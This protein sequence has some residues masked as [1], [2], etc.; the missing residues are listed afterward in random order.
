MKRGLTT[1]WAESPLS[2]YDWELHGQTHRLLKNVPPEEL[3][4]WYRELIGIYLGIPMDQLHT[5]VLKEWVIQ[6]GAGAV[7]S[8][9]PKDMRSF[10]FTG[11]D[12]QAISYWAAEKPEEVWA[13]LK[14]DQPEAFKPQVEGIL[15]GV[16]VKLAAKDF[17][18]VERELAARQKDD[19]L[20][21][22]AML[23]YASGSAD[24]ALRTR[25]LERVPQSTPEESEAMLGSLM[26]G[27]ALVDPAEATAALS[28]LKVPE[29]VRRQADLELTAGEAVRQ[30]DHALKGWLARNPGDDAFPVEIGSVADSWANRNPAEMKTWIES[31]PQGSRKDALAARLKA[32]APG[33]DPR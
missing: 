22:L 24:P 32:A 26:R 6:D 3:A 14:G 20:A 1:D 23:G 15:Q 13:W 16:M 12:R 8:L 18:V 33:P 19:R 10:S 5:Q 2:Y 28:G 4:K 17:T 25:L 7:A 31:L 30:P 21:L 9:R 27:W 29:K 11:Q